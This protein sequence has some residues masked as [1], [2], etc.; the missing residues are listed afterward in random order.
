MIQYL[1]EAQNVDY[2]TKVRHTRIKERQNGI[3]T[4]IIREY[5]FRFCM[6]LVT[7]MYSRKTL[8]T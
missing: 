2:L 8:L 1:F 5:M 7:P 3:E 4:M 6:T